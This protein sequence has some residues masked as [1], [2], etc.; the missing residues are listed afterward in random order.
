VIILSKI[1]FVVLLLVAL[2]FIF[3]TTVFG[4]KSDAMSGGSSTI[5]TTYRGKAGFDDAMSRMTFILGMV[6]IGLCLVI[7][8]LQQRFGGQ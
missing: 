4:S 6:F 2:F 8:I 3:I 1:L 5:R 7:D